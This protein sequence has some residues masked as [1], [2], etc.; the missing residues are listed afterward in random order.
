MRVHEFV[1]ENTHDFDLDFNLNLV[2]G[3]FMLKS[4]LECVMICKFSRKSYLG[5]TGQ[6]KLFLVLQIIKMDQDRKETLLQIILTSA[7]VK[8]KIKDKTFSIS[9]NKTSKSAVW[10]TFQEVTNELGEKIQFVYCKWCDKVLT[11]NKRSYS[12]L[13]A[14][15]CVRKA[16]VKISYSRFKFALQNFR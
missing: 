1:H 2:C 8:L 15:P 6:Y 4:F 13:L 7:E 16:V 5:Q 14:H 11:K 12:N 10:D 9:S 3:L